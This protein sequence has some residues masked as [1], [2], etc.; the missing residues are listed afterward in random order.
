MSLRR[1]PMPAAAAAI[2][3]I[4]E[5]CRGG[6]YDPHGV[7][8][9]D[10]FLVCTTGSVT[11]WPGA[12]NVIA[13]AVNFTVDIRSDVDPIRLGA[14]QFTMLHLPTLCERRGVKCDVTLVHEAPATSADPTIVE[15]LVHAATAAMQRMRY[16]V[17]VPSTSGFKDGFIDDGT[18]CT[19]VGVA[20]QTAALNRSRDAVD[21]SAN[22]SAGALSPSMQ[23]CI[24]NSA[25]NVP[26]L[27]SGAGHDALAMA[28]LTGFGMLFVR[29]KDGISH[30]PAEFV[31]QHDVAASVI[32]LHHYL[33]DSLIE[34]PCK[35][36]I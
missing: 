2:L 18:L 24:W 33:T 12:S 14:T 11:L 35:A 27:V 29:C 6:S 17:L 19:D 28:T 23:E 22:C 7:R 31:A 9:A 32:A 26:R 16:G 15:R 3:A 30:S 10:Q 1:D 20:E 13:G 4:E 34:Q 21:T 36:L 8:Y 25:R 5:Y